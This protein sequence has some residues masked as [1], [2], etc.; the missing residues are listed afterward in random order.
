MSFSQLIKKIF[1]DNALV[2]E[3]TPFLIFIPS[4]LQFLIPSGFLNL[5]WTS[6]IQNS[7]QKVRRTVSFFPLFSF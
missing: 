3:E 6:W 2:K 1:A 7:S 4:P 5:F